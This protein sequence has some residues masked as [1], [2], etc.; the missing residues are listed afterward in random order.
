KA[1]GELVKLSPEFA[2]V[3]VDLG[4]AYENDGEL[5]KALENYQKAIELNKRQYATAFLRTGIVYNRKGDIDK[6]TANFDD[7]ERLYRADSNN[8][9]LNEVY[10]QRGLLF[11]N[12]GRYEEAKKHF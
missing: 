1:Y 8:E 5:D 12:K 2:P 7:A 10:R 3:Y 6:A 11:K 4:Y 9:G